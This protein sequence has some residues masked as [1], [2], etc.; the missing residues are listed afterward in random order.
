[1]KQVLIVKGLASGK[2]RGTFPIDHLKSHELSLME[3][4][5]EQKITIASSCLGKGQCKKCLINQNILSCQISL[6][7]FI[8]NQDQAI[9]EVSYL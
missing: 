4:L 9:V 1:M 5:L 8:Q 2:I 7:D 6:K 3:F